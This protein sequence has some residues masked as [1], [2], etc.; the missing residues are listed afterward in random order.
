MN[1]TTL[2][3]FLDTAEIPVIEP[4][5]LT[6][7]E[8]AKQPHYENVLSNIYAFFFDVNAEHGFKELFISTLVALRMKKLGLTSSKFEGFYD[9][10]I[11]TE[12]FTKKRGRIDI[13]LHNSG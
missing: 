5:P 7:L 2:Q 11:E 13:L 1:L 6:F 3:E 10:N 9:F 4:K 12:Y 8:I